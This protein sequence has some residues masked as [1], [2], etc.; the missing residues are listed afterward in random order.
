MDEGIQKSQTA[1]EGNQCNRGTDHQGI[2]GKKAGRKPKEQEPGV[3]NVGDLISVLQHYFPEFT[4]WLEGLRDFRRPDR[5]IFQ[6]TVLVLEMILERLCGTDA[7]AHLTQHRRE[8]VF[9]QNLETLLGMTLERL[10]HG[11]TFAY[12]Y[13]LEAKLVC[14]QGFV[15]SIGPV[16][17]GADDLIGNADEIKTDSEGKIIAFPKQDC[18]LKAFKRLT[19]KIH[20]QFPKWKFMLLLDGLYMTRTVIDICRL[21]GW[22]FSITLKEGS[23]PNLYQAAAAKIAQ[24]THNRIRQKDGTIPKWCNSAPWENGGKKHINSMSSALLMAT[25]G[26]FCMHPVFL[27][28]RIMLKNCRMKSAEKGG[29]SKIRDS[30]N[31]NIVAW[32]WRK[33]LEQLDSLHKTFTGLCR[34]RT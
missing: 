6:S 33:H 21:F 22:A 2:W 18:E 9:K 32:L 13:V 23:A 10:P 25:R 24:D 17:I 30:E 26:L 19:A 11:D 16:F 20:T 8:T 4:D 31:K 27:F 14:S 3:N 1:A 5:I 12:Y 34:S 28:I 7:R 29:K 15:F